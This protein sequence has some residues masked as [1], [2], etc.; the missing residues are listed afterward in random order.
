MRFLQIFFESPLMQ[1]PIYAAIDRFALMVFYTSSLLNNIIIT[2][3]K[4]QP[5]LLSSNSFLIFFHQILLTKGGLLYFLICP[6]VRPILHCCIFYTIKPMLLIFVVVLVLPILYAA[7][8]LIHVLLKGS[9]LLHQHQIH[10][11]MPCLDMWVSTSNKGYSKWLAKNLSMN[12]CKSVKLKM[13]LQQN[14][15]Y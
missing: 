9:F 7:C 13:L 12:L 14:K 4:S 2:C 11:C 8:L 3:L 5:V 10:P 15:L 1:S 6:L